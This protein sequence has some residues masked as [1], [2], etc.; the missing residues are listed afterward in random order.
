MLDKGDIENL[1]FHSTLDSTL[2]FQSTLYFI[3]QTLSI[4]GYAQPLWNINL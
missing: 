3:S 1:L 2:L 4:A